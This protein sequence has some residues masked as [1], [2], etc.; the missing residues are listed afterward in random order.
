LAD[1]ADEES[2]DLRGVDWAIR[3][4]LAV[5]SACS[6]DD[7]LILFNSTLSCVG[8]VKMGTI[9]KVMGYESFEFDGVRPIPLPQRPI[10]GDE[11]TRLRRLATVVVSKDTQRAEELVQRL[12]YR[13]AWSAE[14]TDE[15]SS[16][17][18][19]KRMALMAR[20][21]FLRL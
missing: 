17:F 20:K 15:I 13:R 12:T 8:P 10:D 5:E 7:A 16:P 3:E 19:P 14:D 18:S 9:P 21:A 11:R 4:I 2:Y 6:A 1:P